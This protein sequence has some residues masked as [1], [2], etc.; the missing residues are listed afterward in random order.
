LLNLIDHLP[1]NTWYQA[2]VSEDVDHA[3]MVLRAQEQARKDGNPS[4]GPP[5]PSMAIWS[6]EVDRLTTIIDVLRGVMQAVIASGGGRAKEQKPQPRPQSA[7]EVAR[8]RVKQENHEA[9]KARL[10]PRHRDD[11]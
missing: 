4:E 9:L 2:A 11:E 7:M 5:A 6:P 10:L 1:Q 8:L 3:K